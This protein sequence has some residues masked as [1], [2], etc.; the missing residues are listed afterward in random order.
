MKRGRTL[1]RVQE[2]ID[3]D[4]VYVTGEIL[5]EPVKTNDGK[6]V[7]RAHI[8]AKK[9]VHMN[10]STDSHNLQGLTDGKS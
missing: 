2:L 5:Y 6:Y 10:N 9:V 3:N 7:S 4:L 1:T 8:F